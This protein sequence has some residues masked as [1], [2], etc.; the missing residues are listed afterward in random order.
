[1]PTKRFLEIQ[2]CYTTLGMTSLSNNEMTYLLKRLERADKI[3]EAIKRD[4]F[5]VNNHTWE[6]IQVHLKE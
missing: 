4:N 2:K 6:S 5:T 1:M 3:I